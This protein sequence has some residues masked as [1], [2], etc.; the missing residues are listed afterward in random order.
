MTAVIATIAVGLGPAGVAVSPDGTRAY[1][2]NFTD[3]TVSA[4][5]TATNTVTATIPVGTSSLG[6]VDVAVSPH[7]TRVYVVGDHTVSVI[8]TA[9]STVSATI[10]YPGFA[11]AAAMSR[12]GTRLYLPGG[13]DL[14]NSVS[15][16]D[17]NPTSATYNLVIAT[18]PLSSTGSP[19]GV[20]VSNRF[21]FVTDTVDSTVWV[22][23][24]ETNTVVSTLVAGAQP[25][26]VAVAYADGPWFTRIYIPLAAEN[27]VIVFD[28]TGENANPVAYELTRV[29][30]QLQNTLIEVGD[31]PA[32]AS[33]SPNGTR[34][35]VTNADG[36]TISVIDASPTSASYNQV[37]ATTAVGEGPAGV[38][39]SPDNT[40]VYVTNGVSNTVSVINAVDPWHPPDLFGGLLGGVDRDGGGWLVIGNKFIPI[41]PRSPFL[42]VVARA[43]APH[44]DQAIENPE[45]GDHLRHLLQARSR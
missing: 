16:I 33:A 24:I 17:T 9:T 6:P 23:N 4:I 11:P 8:D 43:A 37:I 45:L 28:E 26:D 15:V 35:Y 21:V 42:S 7:N 44:L 22:I 38:A 12:D 31:A 18:I 32:A 5:D 25:N 14:D 36:N 27:K 10:D 41:P 30:G 29:Q 1:V 40:R 13:D 2:A 3:H 20:A 19:G 34:I 39:V